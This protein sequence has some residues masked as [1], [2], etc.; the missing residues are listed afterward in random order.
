[1]KTTI[2]VAVITAVAAI[3]PSVINTLLNTHKEVEIK[4]IDTLLNQKL[5]YIENFTV[6]YTKLVTSPC[7]LEAMNFQAAA[8][9]LAVICKEEITKE[10][11]LELEKLVVSENMRTT[12]TD[13]LYHECISLIFKEIS[14]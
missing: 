9:Q 4:K 13:S 6:L 12:K 1:M 10:K 5:K 3:L 14:V 11:L 7:Y 2:I 8:L